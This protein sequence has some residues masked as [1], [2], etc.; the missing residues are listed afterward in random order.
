MNTFES[1]ALMLEAVR[2]DA[3]CY[4]AEPEYSSTFTILCKGD[5]ALDCERDENG[6]YKAIVL[7]CI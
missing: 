4:T 1:I 5:Y 2:V 6:Q 7:R 3:D